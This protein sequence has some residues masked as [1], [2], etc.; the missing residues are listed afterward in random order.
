MSKLVYRVIPWFTHQGENFTPTIRTPATS[1]KSAMREVRSW[2]K[3]RG[4]QDI[5]FLS[6]EELKPLDEYAL[7][8]LWEISP[9][10]YLELWEPGIST[11]TLLRKLKREYPEIWR[12][13]IKWRL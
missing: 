12:G 4:V 6:V 2:Y 11:S 10:I 9:D 5:T 13:L 8:R 3:K 7:D 1:K